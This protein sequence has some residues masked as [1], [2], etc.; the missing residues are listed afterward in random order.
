MTTHEEGAGVPGAVRDAGLPERLLHSELG[1]FLD[2]LRS[3]A[4]D[5]DFA[6][7]TCCPGWSVRHVVAHCSAA[8][9]RVLEVRYGKG[10]FSPESN[11]RD[12]AERAGWPV[13]ALLDELERGYRE[14]GAVMGAWEDGALDGIA[15][16]EWTHTGDVREAWGVDGAYGGPGARPAV[17]LLARL[18]YVRKFPALQA[19]LTDLGE[20]V[21]LGGEGECARY[22]GDVPTLMRLFSGRPLTG[23]RYRLAGVKEAELVFFD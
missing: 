9:N 7:R 23:T 20:T 13:G 18:T 1:P 8:L 12:I 4:T 2:L 22:A 19:E 5:E 14:A 17:E 15:L 10:V 3:R 6:I 11:D 21:R 16:G